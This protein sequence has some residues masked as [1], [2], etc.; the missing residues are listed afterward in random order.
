MA[1][2]L[3][4]HC[5][6]RRFRDAG[7]PAAQTEVML[8]TLVEWRAADV[9]QLA[10]K[11]DLRVLTAELAAMESRLRAGIAGGK[12]DILKWIIPLL[13]GQILALMALVVQLALKGP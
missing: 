5:I 8:E 2:V 12:A 9:R 11:D 3:D 6:A 1:T 7:V 10:S 13:A 4:T